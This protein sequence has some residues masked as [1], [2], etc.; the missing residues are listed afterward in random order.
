MGAPV[1]KCLRKNHPDAF[2]D[3]HMMVSHPLKWV[4]DIA[5]AGGSMFTFHYECE[6]DTREVIRA[7]K[8]AGMKCGLAVK[9]GTNV[10]VLDEFIGEIDMALVMTVEPGFGGQSFMGDMMPKVEYLREKYPKLDIEVDGGLGPATIDA[11]A[12]A[13]ANWIVAGSSVYKSPDPK[14]VIKTLRNSVVKWGHGKE[15]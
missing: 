4:K 1:I 2:F 14:G 5:E 12:K 9:P 11:A 3:C 10:E 15:I 6:D 8:Q 7:V 13:G